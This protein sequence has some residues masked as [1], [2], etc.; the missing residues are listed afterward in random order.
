MNVHWPAGRVFRLMAVLIVA[1]GMV[2][3]GSS[4]AAASTCVSW[5]GTPP[6]NPSTAGDAFS[7][8]AV[9]SPCDVFA[10]GNKHVGFADQ[11]LAEQWNGLTWTVLPSGNPGGSSRD[12][13]LAG[14]AAT[15][16][17]TAWAV[18]R[19]D[20]GVADQTLIQTLVGGV[21]EQESSPNPG[22][23]T[24]NNFLNAIAATSAKNAWAVGDYSSTGSNLLTLIAHWN[25]TSWS[26]VPSPS[27]SA[28]LNEL[29]GVAATS[30]RNAWAVGLYANS[31]NSLQTLIEHWNGTSWKRVP[32]PNP[33]G[34]TRNNVVS[35]V[36][37]SSASNAWAVGGYF[38]S[39]GANVPLAEHWNGKA[40]KA[41]PTPSLGTPASGALGGVTVL[42]GR[43]AWA[44][45]T[46]GGNRTLAEH[47]TG[48]AWHRIPTPNLGSFSELSGVAASSP[49]TIW[50]VGGYNTGGP[51]LTLALHCC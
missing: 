44:V 3:S 8:V 16:A 46:S 12:N 13:D 40:W 4:L 2:G 26:Q 43:D 22:G 31:H 42:S 37:A 24:R 39:S 23:S 49:A 47:W 9:L 14:V 34:S 6:V 38:S 30:A 25:G 20:N 19:Y 28:T 51:M 7:A 15:S 29:L 36:A 17:H 48:S 33:G 21:W 45:G 41:V 1:G 32:S 5:A 10:V 18:G 11:T 35:A 27:P 50:A